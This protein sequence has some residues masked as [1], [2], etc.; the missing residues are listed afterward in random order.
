LFISAALEIFFQHLLNLLTKE[1]LPLNKGI[2]LLQNSMQIPENQT[3][4]K[5]VVKNLI[6]FIFS[7]K[8]MK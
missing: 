7:V 4:N 6:F 8:I 3:V 2:T 1:V 5:F